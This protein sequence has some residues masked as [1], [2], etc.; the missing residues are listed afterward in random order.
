MTQDDLQDQLDEIDQELATMRHRGHDFGDHWNWL[1]D[2]K[3]ALEKK[4]EAL[5]DAK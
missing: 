4:L 1:H 2:K 3:A 5:G